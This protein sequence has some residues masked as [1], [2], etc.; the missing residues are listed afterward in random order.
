[1]PKLIKFYEKNADKRDK[2]EILAFHDSSA[3]SVKEI[4]EKLREKDVLNEHWS[5]KNL[6]F[7]VLVDDTRSTIDGWGIRAFPTIVLIDPQGRLVKGGS[8]KMLKEKLGI[9]SSTP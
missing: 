7:P 5:G 1:M 6:P 3:K 4:D 8:L 9:A 2:F